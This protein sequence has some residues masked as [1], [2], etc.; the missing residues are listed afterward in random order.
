MDKIMWNSL[1]I[2]C[3][4]SFYGMRENIQSNVVYA[5]CVDVE[6]CIKYKFCIIKEKKILPQL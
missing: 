5:K 6:H 4:L 2:R 1:N 3:H